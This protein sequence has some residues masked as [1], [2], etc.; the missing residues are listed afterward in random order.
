MDEPEV[1]LLKLG[2]GL[3]L[4]MRLETETLLTPIEQH[5]RII[6]P[7]FTDDVS[8]CQKFSKIVVRLHHLMMS[9]STLDDNLLHRV[10]PV[11]DDVKIMVTGMSLDVLHHLSTA[12][13]IE[14]LCTTANT[15]HGNVSCMSVV[16]I[17]HLRDIT[18]HVVVAMGVL[19]TIQLR[20]Y[21][22]TTHELENVS[23]EYIIGNGQAIL[24]VPLPHVLGVVTSTNHEDLRLG[25]TFSPVPSMHLQNSAAL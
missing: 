15:H 3:I 1:E 23:R 5:F 13:N 2:I 24:F 4:G 10:F 19:L 22:F 14:E 17:T 9:R 16:E 21:V 12:H 11:G 20:C 6:D 8:V 18:V 25:H 7:V